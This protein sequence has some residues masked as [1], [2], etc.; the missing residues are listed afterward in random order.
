MNGQ[1]LDH[2]N[3]IFHVL[4]SAF[5][6][7]YSCQTILLKFVE[8][9]KAALESKTL[10][11]A[12]FMDLSKAFDCLPHGLLISKLHAY[13]LTT[14]ACKLVG[15]YLSGRRQRVKI[16]ETKS[17]WAYLTKG[18]PQGSILGPLLFNIFINDMFY[19]IEK[20]VLYNFADDNSL[21]NIAPSLKEL[22]SNLQHD[23]K[24][25]LK[26][27]SD[28]GMAANPSKF[29]F[30]ISSSSNCSE[31]ELQVNENVTIKSEP[32]VK[33]LGVYIDNKLTF[34]E[35]VKRTCVKAARQLNALSRISKHLNVSAKK[36]IFRSFI[37]SN[38]T[39][40]SI[41]WH[42]CGSINNNKMEKIQERALKIVYDDYDSEYHDLIAKFG[43]DTMLQSRLKKIVL[44]VFKSLKEINPVYIRDILKPKD[45]PY[46]LRNPLLLVQSKMNTTNFGL[47]S[48]TYLS[49]KLWNELPAD[50]KDIENVDINQFKSRLK[51]WTAPD[52]YTSVNPLL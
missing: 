7:G 12:V 19:F 28:N 48:Y 8:D 9:I 35:H 24:I 36:Q 49:S 20:G 11:G 47:R 18:V 37:L 51:E 5:R 30:M 17:N 45:Q 15:S 16:R 21:L 14:H 25:C 26:W 50:F 1:L 42:F 38:F 52:Q 29:Q 2:F 39:Y 43:T 3:D 13:G 34:T 10:A 27:Y 4:L 23:S 32:F 33:A 31:V 22:L 44:E 41:V 40:C 46:F 6:K